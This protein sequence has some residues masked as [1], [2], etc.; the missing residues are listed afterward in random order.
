MRLIPGGDFYSQ[1]KLDDVPDILEKLKSQ[2]V[3]R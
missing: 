1:V 2:S 3:S